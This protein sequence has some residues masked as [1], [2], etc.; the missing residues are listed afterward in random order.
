[1]SLGLLILV[2]VGKENL[3]L[4][5]KPEI[6]YFKI[7]YKRYTNYAIEPTPQYFKTTP[8]FG[9]RCTVNIGKNADLLGL[10]YLYIKLPDIQIENF[11]SDTYTT[12]Q[13][14]LG[15]V[16]KADIHPIEIL[17]E[18]NDLIKYC[19]IN[20]QRNIGC[21]VLM[22][23]HLA[24]KILLRDK[25][26]NRVAFMHIIN[27]I[28]SRYKYSLAEGG[29]MVG[30]LAAQSLGEKTTQM[31]LHSVDWE[32]EIIIAKN[33]K[34]ITPKIGEF[35]DDYYN[36]CLADPIRKDKIQ[37]INNGT[38]I[39]IPLDDGNDWK[40]YSCDEN[41][42]VMWTKLE[43]ITRHPVVNKDGTETI[44]EVELECGRTVKAT[45]GKSF[46]VYDEVYN[47]IVE[48]SGDE[49]QVG[50]LIPVCEGLKLDDTFTEYT[51]ID[52][53]DYL[54]PKDYLY[55]DEVYKALDIMNN[56]DRKWFDNNQGKNFILPYT[57][58][59][60]FKKSFTNNRKN[61]LNVIQKGCIYPK[62][63]FHNKIYIANIPEQIQLT[64]EFG[65]FIGAYLADGMANA[66]RIIISKHDDDFFR[67]QYAIR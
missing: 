20:G 27:A 47:K 51:H 31:T 8:D 56:G 6:T 34:L 44:L 36:E 40:A 63:I 14:K 23:N 11:V 2:S 21:E 60:I 59:T 25:K 53:K 57:S 24:P 35:I 61:I 52:V 46:L 4:S 41:G 16:N 1:M 13:F 66:Y 43:A 58:G 65:Y 30:P 9:R 26:F 48:I 62:T 55:S 3:Y 15:D 45:K 42:E 7:A 18:V 22:W 64:K 5:G 32:T 19:T 28:K 17:N 33:G 37:Y 67:K 39:Y 38:Q 54:S 49:L 50:H 12:K 10:T 29:E